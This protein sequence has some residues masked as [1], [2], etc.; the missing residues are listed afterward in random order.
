VSVPYEIW[1]VE[2]VIVLQAE[3]VLVSALLAERGWPAEL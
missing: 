3:Y 1:Y 2:S